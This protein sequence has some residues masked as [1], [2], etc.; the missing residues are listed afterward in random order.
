M[1][2]VEREIWGAVENGI[3]RGQLLN[4]SQVFNVMIFQ[5]NGN[6]CNSFKACTKEMRNMQ[7]KANAT[8][9]ADIPYNFLIGGDGQTY[10]ARGWSYSSGILTN[11][12]NTSFTVGFMGKFH[13]I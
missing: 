10:E 5:T 8:T 1:N 11:M 4:S 9:F 6:V 2:L 7:L 13:E 12:K 3:P